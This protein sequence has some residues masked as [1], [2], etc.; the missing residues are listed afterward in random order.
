[1][2]THK[3]ITALIWATLAVI[4]YEVFKNF[5]ASGSSNFASAANVAADAADISAADF[6]I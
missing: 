4:A 3:V 5:S 6:F 2:E 1:M